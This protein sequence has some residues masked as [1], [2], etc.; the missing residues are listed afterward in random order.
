VRGKDRLSVEAILPWGAGQRPLM[1]APMQGLTNS[2]LRHL[3][4]QK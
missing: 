2:A 3:Y 1:L 4:L